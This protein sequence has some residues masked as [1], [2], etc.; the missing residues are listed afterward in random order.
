MPMWIFL[1]CLHVG[2]Q[3]PNYH[4]EVMRRWP[5][6]L[7]VTPSIYH[8]NPGANRILFVF[9][10]NPRKKLRQKVYAD[11]FA[12]LKCISC[13]WHTNRQTIH[14]V[15]P[16]F[17][18]KLM[19]H[20]E[21]PL[22][23]WQ[24]TSKELMSILVRTHKRLKGPPQGIQHIHDSARTDKQIFNHPTGYIQSSTIIQPSVSHPFMCPSVHLT[25][26]F[27]EC[28]AR[29]PPE[30]WLLNRFA[31]TFRLLY[32]GIC[33]THISG[34]EMTSW[35][36]VASSSSMSSSPSYG[37]FLGRTLL[38]HWFLRVFG[39]GWWNDWP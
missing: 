12:F 21:W 18:T 17:L 38:F 7:E 4:R 35:I 26:I 39:W 3:C 34:I 14:L 23:A 31:F 10:T 2:H 22:N 5:I 11:S 8:H 32:K 30:F 6:M 9:F 36:S 25:T 27:Q 1:E 20:G 37:P 13:E 15:P 28:L 29:S 19:W 33:F 24:I 16:G